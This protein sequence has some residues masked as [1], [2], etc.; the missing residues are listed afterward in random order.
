MHTEKHNN[1]D[2]IYLNEI[3]RSVENIVEAIKLHTEVLD[4][5]LSDKVW[6]DGVFANQLRSFIL[7]YQNKIKL[8]CSFLQIPLPG[9]AK[10]VP[11]KSVMATFNARNAFTTRRKS[12]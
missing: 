9:I 7:Y 6:P 2:N 3:N 11:P 8:L 10:K 12:A 5:G 1:L 4:Q